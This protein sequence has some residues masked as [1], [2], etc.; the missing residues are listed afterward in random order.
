MDNRT[1][2]A[3]AS[4]TTRGQPGRAHFVVGLNYENPHLSPFDEMQRWKTH[5]EVRSTSKAASV[6][7]YARAIATGNI[8]SLPRL[9]FLAAA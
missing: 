6:L 5:A 1:M 2:A 8:Q 4:S 3:A 7:A 9:I